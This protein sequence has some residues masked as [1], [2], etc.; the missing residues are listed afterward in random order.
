MNPTRAIVR[1]WWR[2]AL[3]AVIVLVSLILTAPRTPWENDEFLFAE[4]VR[5]FDP[6]RYHPHPPGYPLLVIIGKVFGAVVHDPWRALVL[7]SIVAA[8]ISSTAAPAGTWRTTRKKGHVTKRTSVWRRV[9]IS[10]FPNAR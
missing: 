7:F 5:N 8:P 1:G 4:A 2:E 3:G 9:R 10:N 6:S